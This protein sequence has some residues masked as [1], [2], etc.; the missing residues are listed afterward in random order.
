MRAASPQKP[1]PREGLLVLNREPLL[2]DP[3]I[4][5]LLSILD[6][7]EDPEGV[8][9]TPC[10]CLL[11]LHIMRQFETTRILRIVFLPRHAGTGVIFRVRSKKFA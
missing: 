7:G 3:H 6:R 1:F 5:L 4:D 11:K 2:L 8:V 9:F 10:R